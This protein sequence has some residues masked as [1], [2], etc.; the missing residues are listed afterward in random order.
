LSYIHAIYDASDLPQLPPLIG[1]DKEE[2]ISLARRIGT[3]E[4]SIEEY[5]D[6]CSF[7]I[8]KHPETNA[9]RDKVAAYEAQLPLEGLDCPTNTVIFHSGHE[10]GS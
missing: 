1:A 6:I 3:Y 5:C 9:R 4:I 7:L 10:V 8:A 2:I